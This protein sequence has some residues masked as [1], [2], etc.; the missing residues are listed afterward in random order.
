MDDFKQSK[1][2]EY[3]LPANYV[4]AAITGLT[5]SGNIAV[6][7]DYKIKNVI[8]NPPATIVFWND[9]TKTV[10]K[11]D[12]DDKYDKFTGLLLCIAKKLYG[13]TGRYNNEL[14]KWRPEEGQEADIDTV[15]PD[16]QDDYTIFHDEKVVGLLKKTISEMRD[17]DLIAV[18]AQCN[19]WKLP[20]IFQDSLN[21]P[22]YIF[23]NFTS[24]PIEVRNKSI[25]PIIG[26]IKDEIVKRQYDQYINT[27]PLV[28][29]KEHNISYTWE[30]YNNEY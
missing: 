19:N 13:N 5:S 3:K 17:K 4:P 23:D 24:I 1:R 11:C 6:T 21:M 7:L 14:N 25:A 28:S 12:E 8:Y 20:A 26:L 29:Q 15:A 2:S 27:L 10:V 30:K 22:F 9:N 16:N 18:Y